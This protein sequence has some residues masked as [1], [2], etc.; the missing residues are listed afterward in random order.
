M[1]HPL[2]QFSDETRT[3]QYHIRAILLYA[4]M[5]FVVSFL[6][7]PPPPTRPSRLAPPVLTLL[8]FGLELLPVLPR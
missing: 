2:V 1:T 4:A 6:H 8:W 7:L 5:E 3:A